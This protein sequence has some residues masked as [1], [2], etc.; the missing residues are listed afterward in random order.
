MEKYKKEISVS[1]E[2]YEL[3]EEELEEIKR[4]ERVKGRAE[5]ADYIIYCY[6]NYIYKINSISVIC[7]FLKEI[8]DFLVRDTN[9]ISNMKKIDFFDYVEKR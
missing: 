9:G 2:F 5:L 1:K 4:K 8:I 6:N 7:D 3:S